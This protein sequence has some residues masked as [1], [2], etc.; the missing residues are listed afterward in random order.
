MGNITIGNL[1]RK[2]LSSFFF[3]KK[4]YNMP[5]WAD[6]YLN[7]LY[8]FKLKYTPNPRRKYLSFNVIRYIKFESLKKVYK[9][10][11]FIL[12]DS[13]IKLCIA[14]LFTYFNTKQGCKSITPSNY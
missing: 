12:I 9:K 11:I 6:L 4:Y 1:K 10:I 3:L 8:I 13:Y 2:K 7:I 5:F 14:L